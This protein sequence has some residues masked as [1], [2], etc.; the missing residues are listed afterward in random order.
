MSSKLSRIDFWETLAKCAK[1]RP[2]KVSGNGCITQ[3]RTWCCP[4]TAVARELTGEKYDCGFY[5]DA[6]E[7]MGLDA[8]FAVDVANAADDTTSVLESPKLKR[9]RKKL[10]KVLELT[11]SGVD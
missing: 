3:K 9:L 10:L 6:A 11:E 5:P 4:I 8:K 2:F 1:H 7:A